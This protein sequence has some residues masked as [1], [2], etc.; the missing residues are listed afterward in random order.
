[1]VFPTLYIE[2]SLKVSW[3]EKISCINEIGIAGLGY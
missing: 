2:K 3:D 1:M